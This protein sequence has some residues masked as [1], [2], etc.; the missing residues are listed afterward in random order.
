M[1]ITSAV[2]SSLVWLALTSPA[3]GADTAPASEPAVRERRGLFP[4]FKKKDRAE[5]PQPAPPTATVKGTG[6]S[7][8]LDPNAPAI[9]PVDP[10]QAAEAPQ[11]GI[12]EW[13][14][15][16]EGEIPS[17]EQVEALEE[18]TAEHVAERAVVD[19][20]TG[21]TVPLKFY[22][23]PVAALAVDPLFLDRV[24]PKE[25][26]IPIEV[27]PE[28]EKWIRYFL[29]SGRVYYER[30]LGRSTRYQPMMRAALKEAGLPQDLVYLS[31]I[32]SG[33]NTHAYS[34]SDAAGLW[35]FIPSTGKVY[36]LRIDYW[37]DDRR[38]PE[39]A[40]DAAITFLGELYKMQG[41]WRL[42]WASYNGGPGRV[43]RSIEKAG[44]KDFWTI[45]RG[46]Y[47]HPETE[48]YV[49]KIMAAA[50]IGKHP[51]RYGFTGIE[52]QDPLVYEVAKV[53]GSVELAV[54][55]KCAG[56]TLDELKGLNPAL[57]RYATPPEGYAV[58]IPVGS[59]DR[60][61]TA[62]AEVPASERLTVVRHTVRRG[63]TLS[64]IAGQYRTSVAS[65][66]SANQLRNV[67]RIYVGMELVIPHDDGGAV[68]GRDV[69]LASVATPAPAPAKARPAPAPK[70]KVHV[71]ARG[72]T[73]TKI[74]TAYG[75]TV[76]QLKATNNLRSSTIVI[77][78]RLTVGG[79]TASAAPAATVTKA[80]SA[81]VTHVVKPGETLTRI[82]AKYGIDSA[83]LQKQNKITD[84]SHIE[85]GQRL[86]VTG[87]SGTASAAPASDWTTYT[88]QRGDS[89]AKIATRHGCTT[90]ELQTWNKLRTSVLQP[91][92]KLKI[93]GG[94]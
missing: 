88:V 52:F 49:P 47:L 65:I 28:V 85:V 62:L 54:L 12:W 40:L 76:T 22:E 77:G 8:T 9:E 72:D 51:E 93:K 83:T 42:A 89:L 81:P 25:F 57:R 74:A 11:E 19:D 31:M 16:M 66:S 14:D 10:N 3:R 45:A 17:A 46:E 63:E 36:D 24:D 71:V 32:E 33:Y 4:P 53:E 44:T 75:T 43:R 39:F 37:V 18:V 69:V 80:T 6:V 34:H 13:V 26:D 78:Q 20:L 61:L 67:N 5:V 59:R 73:L 56:T 30:W 29:G 48:N 64:I 23:D 21:G 91:G 90:E 38:D 41:D 94:G 50:I 35:Q 70:P 82:A 60:F 15:R 87:G 92:Q 1:N 84:P 2:V 27:N 58:R 7:G 79:G 68:T 86:T 55:A